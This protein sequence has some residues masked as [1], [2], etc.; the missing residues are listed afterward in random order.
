MVT[1]AAQLEVVAGKATGTSIIVDDE[2][3]IGRQA[4]GAGR[5]ADDDEISRA[6][7]RV[8][9]DP[10]GFCAI[11]DL[12]STNGTYVNGLRIATPVTLGT[13]DTIEV[14]T[15]TL[16]VRSAPGSKTPAR[17]PASLSLR[18]DVDFAAGEVRLQLDD[19]SKPV[20][21]VLDGDTWRPEFAQPNEKG[22]PR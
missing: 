20:R 17:T 2:L 15:T 3:L 14:G 8:T 18:V 11:E 9:V 1:G 16:M 13:G 4:E 22:G 21:F 5:L 12:G 19:A 7:A 6:H 10:G